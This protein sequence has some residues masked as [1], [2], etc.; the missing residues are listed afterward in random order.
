MPQKKTGSR[1]FASIDLLSASGQALLGCGNESNCR[2]LAVQLTL[3]P[4][5]RSLSFVATLPVAGEQIDVGMLVAGRDNGFVAYDIVDERVDRDIDTEG[6]LLIAL[7]QHDIT[8]RA[9]DTF[10][11]CAQPFASHC[12]R[13]WEHRALEIDR[14]LGARIERALERDRLSVRELGQAVGER[15]ITPIVC[16]LI[17]K[18]VLCTDLATFPDRDAWVARRSD[19]LVENSSL[20]CKTAKSTSLKLGAPK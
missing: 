12:E 11:I 10:S 17:C 16:S 3:D 18:R 2:R 15:N 7:D 6:M 13:I 8:L 20:S 5:V 14:C 9:V 4:T 1:R 19:R